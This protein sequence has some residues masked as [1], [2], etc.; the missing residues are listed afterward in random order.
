MARPGNP[1]LPVG[2]CACRRV[3]AERTTRP[4]TTRKRSLI[5]LAVLAAT[6]AAAQEQSVTIYGLLDAPVEHLNN[7]GANRDTVTRM[8]GLTGSFPSRL[9]FRGSE[10]LGDGLRAVFTIETGIAV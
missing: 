10:D 2:P 7:V 1:V 8:P 5:A 6:G 4:E 3:T 9:G